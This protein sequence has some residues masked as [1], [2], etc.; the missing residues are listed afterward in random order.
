MH[1]NNDDTEGME[2]KSKLASLIELVKEMKQLQGKKPRA[3]ALEIHAEKLNPKRL[4]SN[5]LEQAEEL[6]GQDLDNDS[7][8]GESP[9]HQA[10]VLGDEDMQDEYSE[11]EDEMQI[12]PELLKLIAEKLNK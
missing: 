9:E 3:M 4:E 1:D 7:E 5:D 11:E 12:P 2:P 8:L 10:M 6:A